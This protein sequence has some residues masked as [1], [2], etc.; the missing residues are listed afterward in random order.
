MAGVNKVILVGRL[1]RDP[2]V[3]ITNSGNPITTFSMATSEEWRDKNTG[4]K[5]TKTEWHNIVV[6]NNLADIA[7]R[8]L[9][10]GHNVYIEGKLQTT[11][12]EKDGIKRRNTQ[13][14]LTSMN[15]LGG[16]NNQNANSQNGGYPDPP[17]VGG[18][19]DGQ[20]EGDDIPFR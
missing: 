18:Y 20:K 7:S 9:K 14:V 5:K 11:E 10:K 13:I 2:E 19:D 4:E 15:F 17:D 16:N 3:R 8:Y 1:G 6:F 12:Y